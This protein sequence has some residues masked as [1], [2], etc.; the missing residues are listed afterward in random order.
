MKN[1]NR[2]LTGI[3]MLTSILCLQSCE[4]KQVPVITTSEI[5]NIKSKTATG[6]GI[7]TGE[8]SSTIAVRGIS[9]STKINPTINDNKT[10]DG[11]GIGTFQSLLTGLIAGTK[12]YV[13]AYATNIE[14]TF[15]GN[16]ISFQTL[17]G[18]IDFD[19][20]LYKTVT[21]G[22]QV[23][24]AEN[25]KTTH[26]NNGDLIPTTN[27]PT[28]N[29]G[30]S[31]SLKYQ[32]IYNGN[33]SYLNDYG[34]LYTWGVVNDSRGVCPVGWHVPSTAEWQTLLTSVGGILIDDGIT[35]PHFIVG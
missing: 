30:S 7:N 22:N 1:V 25:L 28:L 4:K 2:K 11:L 9:W 23:W 13:R 20:N 8:G 19:D 31:S 15:Y 35:N 34:R 14:G 17:S 26:F 32:W 3:L 29:T 12:Y 27:P 21:I 16:E 10:S 5:T 33:D 24:F 18:A 6:G